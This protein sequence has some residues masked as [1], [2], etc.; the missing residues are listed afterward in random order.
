MKCKVEIYVL[1]FCI[2]LSL[3][4][5]VKTMLY[6]DMLWVGALTGSSVK[7]IMTF[8]FFFFQAEH[9]HGGR[10]R[11]RRLR[12]RGGLG[13]VTQPASTVRNEKEKREQSEE[14]SGRGVRGVRDERAAA[15][16]IRRDDLE[17]VGPGVTRTAGKDLVKSIRCWSSEADY[18]K[19]AIRRY[20]DY[21]NIMY[22]S[23]H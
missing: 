11:V 7:R 21:D 2:D 5:T 16:I 14:R 18:Q 20:R 6:F 13:L 8:D 17:R 19:D 23:T 3:T 15:E 10:R 12:A 9:G 4:I 1:N 22:V